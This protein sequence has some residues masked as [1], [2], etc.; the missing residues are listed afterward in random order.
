M[1]AIRGELP[2]AQPPSP[3]SRGCPP[4]ATPLSHEMMADILLDQAT[5]VGI[6]NGWICLVLHAI[7]G[8]MHKKRLW[9]VDAYTI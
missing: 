1:R 9:R 2:G 5:L 4:L 7:K 8:I 6:E 3:Q